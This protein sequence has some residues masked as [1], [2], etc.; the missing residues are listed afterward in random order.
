MMSQCAADYRHKMDRR[1]CDY[2][3][4]RTRLKT[5]NDENDNKMSSKTKWQQKCK[6]NIKI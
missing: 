2:I 5:K 6:L 1:L 3:L 4:Y